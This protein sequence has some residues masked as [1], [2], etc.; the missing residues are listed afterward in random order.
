MRV[1]L[2]ERKWLLILSFVAFLQLGCQKEAASG[3]VA[4]D[5]VL[6]DLSGQHV[7]LAQHIGKLILLD[8]WA[9]WC[10]PCRMS[11]PELVKLQDKYRDDGLLVIG[12]SMDDPR[13]FTSQ[14]LKKFGEKFKINYLILRSNSKIIEDYFGYESPAIPT[15]FIIDREGRIRDKIV[16]FNPHALDKSLARFLE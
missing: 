11:I 4:P 16:G 8:F 14:Y 5:F 1:T 7:S 3:P 9:T 2:Q 13:Q 10:L 12:V 15:M 6:P